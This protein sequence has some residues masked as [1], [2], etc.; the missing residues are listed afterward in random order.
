MA[1]ATL[2]HVLVQVSDIDSGIATF[3][4]ASGVEAAIGGRHPGKGT[5]NAL[6][7]M[8]DSYLELIATDRTD[9]NVVGMRL[10]H[11]AVRVDD[12][13][14]AAAAASAQGL[15]I[16]WMDGARQT[17]DGQ[18]L[19]WRMFDLTGHP[20]AG[21]LPFFINWGDTPN[22]SGTTPAGLTN[23]VL[24]ASSPDADALRALYRHLGIAVPVESADDRTLRL[25]VASPRG[26]LS[27]SGDAC[28]F[29]EALY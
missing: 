1:I 18:T 13:D 2:D 28:G 3:R 6:A 9:K 26:A 23:P 19:R 12:I 21:T 16:E 10:I 14:A 25:D 8:G 24:T 11:F 17:P 29:R 15:S 7:S 20:H 4:E 22:P 27:L 5:I